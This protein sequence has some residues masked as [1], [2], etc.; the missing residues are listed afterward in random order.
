MISVLMS[1]YNE[2]TNEIQQSI[3]SILSQSYDDFELIIVVDN[4]KHTTAVDLLNEYA[5]KDSRVRFIINKENIGLAMSMNVAADAAKGEYYLRMDADDVCMPDRFQMQYDA[6]KNSKYDLICGNYDFIDENGE[7][8]HQTVHIYTDKQITALLP[9]RNIIHH[10][11][12][13][14]RADTFH[15]V[16]GYRNYKCA[17]DYDLWLRMKKSGCLFHMMPEKLIKYRVRRASTTL[18]NRYKQSCTLVY[19]RNLYGSKEGMDSYSYD[20]YLKFLADNKA[21]ESDA[22]KDFLDNSLLYLNSKKK[23][24]KGQIVSGIRDL[25]RV[26]FKSQYYRPHIMR[27]L[28]IFLITKFVK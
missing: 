6:I 1:I 7:P 16:G 13:I 23:M 21:E 24:V 10:P 12:V 18:Q 3:D 26:L 9:H 19:I 25:F 15:K 14:M 5:E 4:P 17:Q 27:S 2:T 28:L 8:L 22:Q 11:T 20:D